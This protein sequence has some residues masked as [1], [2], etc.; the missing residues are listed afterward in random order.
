MPQETIREIPLDSPPPIAI[1]EVPFNQPKQES[2]R[3]KILSFLRSMLAAGGGIAGATMSTP[4]G[5][6]GMAAGGVMG[7]SATDMALKA[8]RSQGLG[9]PNKELMDTALGGATN[10]AGGLALRGLGSMIPQSAKT[11]A[12]EQLAKLG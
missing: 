10:E 5:P 1:R 12:G 3:D 8:L 7:Y 6:P 9:D 4:L 11:A 2:T